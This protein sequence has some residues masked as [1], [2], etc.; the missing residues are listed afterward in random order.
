MTFLVIIL[1]IALQIFLTYKKVN[2]FLSLLLVAILAGRF[3]RELLEPV[4][5]GL[6][7]ECQAKRRRASVEKLVSQIKRNAL[8]IQLATILTTGNAANVVS[9]KRASH[10]YPKIIGGDELQFQFLVDRPVTA[11]CL[12]KSSGRLALE[13]ALAKPSDIGAD[14]EAEQML[15]IRVFRM[16]AGCKER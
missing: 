10:L 13:F 16:H 2:P 15:G 14:H 9:C 12:G 5:V 1:A 11:P 4:A 8:P 6:Q 7:C 3:C